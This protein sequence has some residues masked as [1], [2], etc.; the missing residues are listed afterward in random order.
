MS[1]D[2]KSSLT[3][4]LGALSWDCMCVVIECLDLQDLA[5]CEQVST[6]RKKF[7]QE[8]MALMLPEMWRSVITYV[9]EKKIQSGRVSALTEVYDAVHFDIAVWTRDLDY[10]EHEPDSLNGILSLG[11]NYVNEVVAIGKSKVYTMQAQDDFDCFF[12]I[13]THDLETGS[14]LHEFTVG[15]YALV[16]IA[17]ENVCLRG[18]NG[19]EVLVT[20]S[21]QPSSFP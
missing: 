1:L 11:D 15:D 9:Q 20:L 8:W 17:P 21:Y 4:P 12:T 14:L 16:K 5:R 18:S 3:D 10:R 2:C 19:R 7:V 13:Q 6:A